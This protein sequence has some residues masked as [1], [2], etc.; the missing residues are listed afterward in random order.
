MKAEME[1]QIKWLTKWNKYPTFDNVEFVVSEG[2]VIND[3]Y[4][5]KYK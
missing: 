3:S 2:M 1:N 5:G 4:D